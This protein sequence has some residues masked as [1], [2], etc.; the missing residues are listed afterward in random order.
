MMIPP[1]LADFVSF[2]K[3]IVIEMNAGMMKSSKIREAFLDG[4]RE[5]ERANQ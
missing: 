2:E 4:T 3:R 1:P 5:K